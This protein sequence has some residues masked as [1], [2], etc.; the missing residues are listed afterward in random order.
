M[1]IASTLLYTPL[2]S[3]PSILLQRSDRHYAKI[4]MQSWKQFIRVFSA[5]LLAQ[6]DRDSINPSRS[7]G[8]NIYPEPSQLHLFVTAK[9]ILQYWVTN[10]PF[11]KM[12]DSLDRDP[13]EIDRGVIFKTCRGSRSIDEHLDRDRGPFGF[14]TIHPKEE[15]HIKMAE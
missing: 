4:G 7:L 5:S 11:A 3:S 1:I 6:P 8:K 13:L 12:T 2:N 9:R 15:S 14:P 10:G